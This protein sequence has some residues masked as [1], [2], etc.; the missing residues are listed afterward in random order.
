MFHPRAP[1]GDIRPF[2]PCGEIL[3]LQPIQRGDAIEITLRVGECRKIGIDG[4]GIAGR[5]QRLERHL[6]QRSR[7]GGLDSHEQHGDL[8][9]LRQHGGIAR[10][11]RRVALRPP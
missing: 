5:L 7:V 1:F 9:L 8:V 4:R 3:C 2:R 11:R 10:D 6:A